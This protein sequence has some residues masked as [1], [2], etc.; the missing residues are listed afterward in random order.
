M[1]NPVI[2]VVLVSSLDLL[3]AKNF[4]CI[5]EAHS[6]LFPGLREAFTCSPFSQPPHWHSITMSSTSFVCTYPHIQAGSLERGWNMQ[7]PRY[8]LARG[9]KSWTPKISVSKQWQR[10]SGQNQANWLVVGG[11]KG[12]CPVMSLTPISEISDPK[13]TSSVHFK[14]L[15][16]WRNAISPEGVD[17]QLL[18]SIHDPLASGQSW[19]L[20]HPTLQST[21]R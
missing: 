6:K 9:E 2:A 12:E 10:S 17:E 20:N 7:C 4:S 5:R 14:Q 19:P 21:C 1:K 18:I 16:S 8:D 15:P 13:S 11:W 3:R